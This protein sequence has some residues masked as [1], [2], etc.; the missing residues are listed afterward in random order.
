MSDR[1]PPILRIDGL[2]CGYDRP[3]LGPLE[4]TLDAGVFLL[5]EGPNG[6]GKS[7]LIKTLIGLV[8]ARGG[9]FRWEP[10]VEDLRY[11][12]QTRTLDPL[13]PATVDDVMRTG[14]MRGGH[15]H[16]LRRPRGADA[17]IAEALDRVGMAEHRSKL[18]R[19]LSEGQK[20]LA[21]LGRALMGEPRVLLLDEPS[22][23][24]DPEREREAVA[25]L[26]RE[27]EARG[28]TVMMIAHGSAAARQAATARLTIDRRRQVRLEGL[29]PGLATNSEAL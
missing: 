21:L 25:V 15:W 3:I 13:L 9:G 16:L 22:A 7:T 27:R 5:I 4:L 29:E 23:S 17:Q 28:L 8:P 12:P 24:M 20:Q 19:E 1:T 11:V 2:I 26:Q 6:V 10:P 18:F 14:L